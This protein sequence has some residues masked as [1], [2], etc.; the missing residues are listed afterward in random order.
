MAIAISCDSKFHKLI[1][2]WVKESLH[3]EEPN[4]H[5]STII[6]SQNYVKIPYILIEGC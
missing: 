4:K 5:G 2:Q 1:I 6:N 3:Y